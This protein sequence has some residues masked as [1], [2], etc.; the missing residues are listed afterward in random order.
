MGHVCGVRVHNWVRIV[1]E[2]NKHGELTNRSEASH[3]KDRKLGAA[4][5]LF[6]RRGS[7]DC[8]TFFGLG[9]VGCKREGASSLL[10]SERRHDQ[11]KRAVL[12]SCL[13]FSVLCDFSGLASLL[14]QF[15]L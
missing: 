3:S 2:G 1:K 5:N 10:S 9:T 15:F 4:G 13:G 14:S 6:S 8:L 7:M 11:E 12:S